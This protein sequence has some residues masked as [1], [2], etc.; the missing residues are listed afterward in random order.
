VDVPD[1]HY[2]RSGDVAIAYQVVGE[3]PTDLVFLP[4][5]SSPWWLWRHPHFEPFANRLA[6]SSRLVLV[7]SRGMGLS[8]RPRALTIEA[9]MDDIRAVLDELAIERCTLLG[10]GESAATCI[11]F[12]ASYP[13][14]LAR[15]IVY[16]P[17]GRGVASEDYPWAA[18]REEWLESF[19]I[20][21]E[22]WGERE[23]MEQLARNTNPQWADD[24]DYVD[25]FVWFHR[26]SVS[27]GAALEYR[28]LQMELDVTD[29]LPAV[30][31]STLVLT[32]ERHRGSSQYVADRIPDSRLVELPGEGN[33]IFEHD[34]VHAAD[35][36]EAFV[37]GY[38]PTEVPDSVL[39][40]ILFTDLVGSTERAAELGD[41]AWRD[42]LGKHHAV[43]RRELARFRGEERDTAGDGFFATFDGPA[44]AIRAA[45]AIVDGA[46]GGG[47]GA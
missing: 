38:A 46:F 36:I 26:H 6:E 33:A 22:H 25:H 10:I 1:V 21:R 2:A 39:A 20:E 9:R 37:R 16:K 40:T 45:Q 30:R 28:R 42:L 44:R 34:G 13:E 47:S 31:V 14:R 29:V 8:D 17:F 43:V 32:K 23:Y 7:N 5:L 41:R 35:A 24:V 19:P 27:P 11:L 18:T 15:L 12:A 4:F 3:G